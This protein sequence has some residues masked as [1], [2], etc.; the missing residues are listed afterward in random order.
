MYTT[1]WKGLQKEAYGRGVINN[2]KEIIIFRPG[3]LLLGKE[4]GK[5][6]IMQDYCSSFRGG[7]ERAHEVDDLIST[8]WEIPGRWVN[9]TCLGLSQVLRLGLVSWAS[10][11]VIPFWACVFV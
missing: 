9:I 3:H 1:K 11:R 10:A 5:G 2:R 7:T 4:T 8:D 6:F